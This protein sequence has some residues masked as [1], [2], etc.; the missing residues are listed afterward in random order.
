MD[1]CL[2]VSE[3]VYLYTLKIEAIR[4]CRSTI[5]PMNKNF[6]STAFWDRLGISLSG[7][8]AIHCLLFPVAVAL[9][10][11]W[12]TAEYLHDWTHPIL[13]L[14]IVPTVIFALRGKG[15]YNKIAFWLFSGLIVVALA[16]ILHD[17]AGLWGE[18]IITMVGSAMLIWGHWHNYRYHQSKSEKGCKV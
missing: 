11:L 6:H 7:L 4:Y 14:M 17:W 12:P 18:S 15:L 16:W 10:P 9:L 5:F 2:G 8:C 1:Y 13:F 3:C